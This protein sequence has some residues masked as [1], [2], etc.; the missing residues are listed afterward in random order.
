[1]LKIVYPICCGMDVHKSFLVACIA[2]TNDHG[3]AKWDMKRQLL[4]DA[5]ISVKG[6]DRIGML[7]EVTKVIS[8]QFDVNIH[9]LTISC[10]EGIFAGVFELLIHDRSD[11][12]TVMNGL[13]TINGVQEVNQTV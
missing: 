7:N 10:D 5:T 12:E 2:S 13:K 11:V 6:I 9:K 4:F 8:D 3:D 1:M